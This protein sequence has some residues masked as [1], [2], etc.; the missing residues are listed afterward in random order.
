[1]SR[2]IAAAAV[3]LCLSPSWLCAQTVRFTVNVESAD[4]HKFPSIGSPVIAQAPR[5]RV[6][7][8]R[9]ELGSWVAVPWPGAENGVAY[10]HVTAGLLAR[11]ATPD[12][13]RATGSATTSRPAPATAGARAQSPQV[14]P[15]TL[16]PTAAPMPQAY[17]TPPPHRVGLGGRLGGS[18]IGVGA[19][20]RAWSADHLGIQLT[21]SHVGLT[22]SLVPEH[23]TSTEIEPSVLYAFR[24]RVTDY[25]WL[26]T[27]IGSG[28]NV[29]HQTT[30][31]PGAI[32]SVSES[33]L[34][35]RAFGGA[36]FALSSAPRFAL[37]V[38]LSYRWSQSERP[39]FDLGGLGLSVSGHWYV[40]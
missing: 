35:V 29:R 11:G 3:V 5:G 27:H 19:S 38:D 17:V 26:R 10:V 2:H 22:S 31:I 37:G 8:V 28:V 40:K 4:V 39:E 1:M 23:L 12:A 24:D 16:R 25:V 34:G 21:L 7:D 33:R 20:A 9:R 14:V 30:R 6:L 36:E 15:P 32:E 13:S 18:T